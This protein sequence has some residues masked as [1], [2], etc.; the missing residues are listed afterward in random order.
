MM[1]IQRCATILEAETRCRKSGW[2]KLL[3]RGNWRIQGT[4]MASHVGKGLSPVVFIALLVLLVIGVLLSPT[5]VTLWGLR[6]HVLAGEQRRE[7]LILETDYEG[8]LEACRELS[9]RATEGQLKARHYN[10][11]IDPDPNASSFPQVILDL[12]PT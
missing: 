12:E 6:Q 4:D 3:V 11:R 9:R 8:L 7:R 5:L 1:I 2:I 10:V